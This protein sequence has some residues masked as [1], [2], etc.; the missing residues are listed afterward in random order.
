[1]K[2]IVNIAI[3]VVAIITCVLAVCFASAFDQD[4]MAN[5]NE[6]QM[7]NADNP[8]MIADFEA[9]TPETLPAFVDQYRSEGATLSE[10]LK[11]QQLQ[12][13]ILYTYI[14]ELGELTEETF[15]E[16]QA[17]FPSHA[18]SLFAQADNAQKYTDGFSA[19][20]DF[21]KLE[22]YISK[23][24]DEYSVI[25]QDYIHQKNYNK[26]YNSIVNQADGVNQVVSETKKAEDLSTLKADIAGY[27]SQGKLLNVTVMFGYLLFF[28]TIA[29][30]LY[31]ALKAIFSNI[32]NSYK[33][34]LVIVA[35][36]ILV[37]IGYLI[38]SPEMTPSAIK[39]QHTVQQVKWIGAG[40]FVFYIAFIGAICAIVGTAISSAIKNRK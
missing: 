24:N 23:L 10:N 4:K 7:V 14:V 35:F 31:F 34:L 37:F 11:A 3:F 32:K 6:A 38:A 27:V 25:K 36:V 12:K 26:A 17:N 8:Q 39:M 19:V 5:Y 16:Y 13:D 20:Q 29:M 28:V 2:K 40:M 33:S 18:K 15:P 21:S 9:T 30:L 22:N 1:M